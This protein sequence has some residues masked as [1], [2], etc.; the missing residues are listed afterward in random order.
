ML[1]S[2]AT[3]HGLCDTYNNFHN[4]RHSNLKRK[5]L[6]RKR[7]SDAFFLYGLLEVSFRRS[8]N[9]KF[10][11]EKNWLDDA[12]SVNINTV[13]DGFSKEWTRMHSCDVENCETVMISD[14]GAKINRAV[15]AQKFS[16]LRK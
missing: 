9:V 12:L 8:H 16:I 2:N 10:H 4:F 3:F 15:C 6:N 5:D 7:L 13:K 14:G 1:H 11:T